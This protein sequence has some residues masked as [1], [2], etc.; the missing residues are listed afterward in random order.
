MTVSSANKTKDKKRNGSQCNH[1]PGTYAREALLP[2]CW[3]SAT[4]RAVRV[5]VCPV[6]IQAFVDRSRNLPRLNVRQHTVG[7]HVSIQSCWHHWKNTVLTPVFFALRMPHNKTKHRSIMVTSNKL[8]QLGKWGLL[9]L[10]LF[11]V[12]LVRRVPVQSIYRLRRTNHCPTCLR[13]S[14]SSLLACIAT[15]DY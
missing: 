6:P 7:A 10:L 8:E 2:A 9:W 13:R 5:H 15:Q 4:Q 14:T 1:V 3:L 11:A 12:R